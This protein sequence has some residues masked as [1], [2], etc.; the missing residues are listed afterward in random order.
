MSY[1]NLALKFI[2]VF[3]FGQNRARRLNTK[4]SA[5]DLETKMLKH[6]ENGIH[7]LS[8]FMSTA[9]LYCQGNT[10]SSYQK[11]NIG[12]CIRA[13]H[14]TMDKKQWM[15]ANCFLYNFSMI[16]YH[17]TMVEVFIQLLV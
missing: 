9:F 13:M 7:T 2:F 14:W 17:M 16:T 12:K 5:K 6:T 11:I 4:C 1:A 8:K 15:N 3:L 10:F